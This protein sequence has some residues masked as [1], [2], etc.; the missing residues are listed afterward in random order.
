MDKLA[1]STIIGYNTK[2]SLLNIANQIILVSPG[3]YT[4]FFLKMRSLVMLECLKGTYVEQKGKVK[5]CFHS[6][7]LDEPQ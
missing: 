3:L 5:G 6:R 4:G 7:H 2:V 1:K